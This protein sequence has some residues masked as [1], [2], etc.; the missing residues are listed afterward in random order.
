MGDVLNY[1]N[2]LIENLD[3]FV[4]DLCRYSEGVLTEQQV[5]KKYH[6]LGEDVWQELGRDD[7]LIEKVEAEKIRRIR[8]GSTKRERAQQLV[9]K[10][11]GVLGD[12]MLDA[13][14]SPKNRIDA[15]KTL[16]ALATPPAQAAAADRDRFIIQINLGTDADGKE[17]VQRFNKS[18]SIKPYDDDVDPN[19]TDTAPQ[20]V[21]AAIATKK[22]ENDD[23]EPV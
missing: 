19:D 17:I 20:D 13:S 21:I 15:S 9:V 6:L 3:D 14:A 10:A 11:P 12:I 4:V 1:P 7:S 2:S 23:G 8:D 22:N 16:D 18:R 5:R